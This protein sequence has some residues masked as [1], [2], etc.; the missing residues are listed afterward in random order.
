LQIALFNHL[1][2]IFFQL[3]YQDT[4]ALYSYIGIHHFA[5]FAEAWAVYPEEGKEN[6]YSLWYK[7]IHSRIMARNLGTGTFYP[8]KYWEDYAVIDKV[9]TQNSK[10]RNFAE[11]GIVPIG[12][13]SLTLYGLKNGLSQQESEHGVYMYC[14]IHKL[15]RPSI[16]K[17]GILRN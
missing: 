15:G 1:R 14:E 10:M 6:L 13:L 5:T 12:K 16:R 2:K 9:G 4:Q 11:F 7:L 8:V 17:C 3:S